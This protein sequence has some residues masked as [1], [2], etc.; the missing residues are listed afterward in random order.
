MHFEFE[1]DSFPVVRAKFFTD[2]VERRSVRVIVIHSMEAPEKGDTAENVAR[3]FQKPGK[4]NGKD[5]KV[6]AHLCIDN[7]SIVQCVFDNDIAFAAPGAN[8]D[9]IQIELAGFARQTRKDWL[10]PFGV[11]MLENAANA[12]A[13]YCLK[14]NIPI[15]HLSNAELKDGAS[16]GIV[17][18][19]QVSKVFKKSTHTDPGKDFP[20]DFFLERV[21]HHHAERLAKFQHLVTPG[22]GT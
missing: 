3:F 2:V 9:G 13:Q 18:H 10:D 22:A 19:V 5:R 17:G 6:S 11:L 8:H 4:L 7:N 21:S 15:K 16:K 20:W 14:Y 1:T 12:T